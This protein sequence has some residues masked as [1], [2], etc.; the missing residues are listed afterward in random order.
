MNFTT[1]G[2]DREV[3]FLKGK[4]NIIL[5]GHISLGHIK[6]IHFS[7][8]KIFITLWP[9]SVRFPVNSINILVLILIAK[10]D[11]TI[12][13]S[14]LSLV[15][16]ICMQEYQDVCTVLTIAE[17][18]WQVAI[19]V[20]N[21]QLTVL[22]VEPNLYARAFWLVLTVILATLNNTRQCFHQSKKNGWLILTCKCTYYTQGVTVFD[23]SVH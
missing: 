10:S 6:L 18:Q 22:T 1:F 19:V 7:I 4:Q 3:R 8:Q 13:P 2:Y 16:W 9:S 11:Q 23:F 14:S 17:L 5:L 20:K 21:S 12:V 15:M